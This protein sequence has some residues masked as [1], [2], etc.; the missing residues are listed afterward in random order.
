M[1]I[2]TNSFKWIGILGR[3]KPPVPTTH[4]DADTVTVRQPSS[5]ALPSSEPIVVEQPCLPFWRTD[6]SPLQLLLLPRRAS[7]ASSHSPPPNLTKQTRI[8][9]DFGSKEV[10]VDRTRSGNVTFDATFPKVY[11]APLPEVDQEGMVSL[12]IFLDCSSVELFAGEGVTSLTA[13]VFPTED[14][15]EMYLFSEKTDTEKVSLH[16]QNVASVWN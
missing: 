4:W 6:T 15:R 5:P 1:A 13:R 16:V 8:G 11:C 12:R 2:Y 7:S 9:Y 14:T 3:E 10:F